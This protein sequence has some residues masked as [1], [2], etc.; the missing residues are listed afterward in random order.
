M[1]RERTPVKNRSNLETKNQRKVSLNSSI[2]SF[3]VS[4]CFCR[5]KTF[6]LQ[7]FWAKTVQN[8]SC[9][10]VEQSRHFRS[11]RARCFVVWELGFMFL[12]KNRAPENCALCRKTCA[13]SVTRLPTFTYKRIFLYDLL[14]SACYQCRLAFH[15]VK[16]NQNKLQL[17]TKLLRIL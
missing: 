8:K 6:H 2:Q 3:Q 7:G 16:K 15:S 11:N 1:V 17:Q 14:F 5:F 4:C 13:S 12:D 10:H 9:R